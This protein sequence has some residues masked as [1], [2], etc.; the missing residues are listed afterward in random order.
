MLHNDV[1]GAHDPRDV[2]VAT[3][4]HKY[5]T[6]RP[7][8]MLTAYD[9]PIARIIDA[10][11]VDG[12]LVGD[13]LGMVVLGH[14]D[15]LSVTLEDMLH[16][17]RA[18][19]RGVTR[20]LLV[21]DMP[22]MSYHVSVEAAVRAAGR[23]VQE[24]G[25]DAVKLEGGGEVSD[26]IR[27]ITRAGIP[28]QGHIGLT[29]QRVRAWGGWKVQARTGEAAASLLRDAQAVEEAGCFS[30][31]V[32]SVPGRV[33]AYITEAIG[34]PTIGIGAGSSTSGQVLVTNDLLGMYGDFQPKF[35]KRFAD[36]GT[37][38]ETAITSYKEEVERREFPGPDH[39]YGMAS[40]E[41]DA[42]VGSLGASE[43]SS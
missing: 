21:G 16:H 4:A 41:W 6:G 3:F 38:I 30:V 32:E 33:A 10:T 25:V 29:P 18:V 7:I 11:G 42:F 17:I 19:R 39:T 22:F 28:V 2:T 20:A 31:V 14:K 37:T 8:T 26:T 35:V 23:L 1:G 15:T 40:D 9:Y 5:A 24:G 13:S 36:L 34:I 27:A 12:V 43:E